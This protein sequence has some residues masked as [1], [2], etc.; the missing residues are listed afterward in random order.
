[1]LDDLTVSVLNRFKYYLKAERGLAENSIKC[2]TEDL[3]QFLHW[4][5]KRFDTVESTELIQYFSLLFEL[6]LASSSVSRKRSS[7]K[8]FYDHLS[9]NEV[10]HLVDFDKILSI[11]SEKY[12]P[13][14]LSVDEMLIILN[15]IER[16][17]A[18]GKRNK[19]ILELMYA[20]GIRI[21]EMLNLCLHD[22]L[23]KDELIRVKGKGNKQRFVPI[24][25]IAIETVNEYLNESRPVL[26]QQNITDVV[27]LNYTGD[28]MSRMGFWKILRQIVIKAGIYKE[29]SPHTIRHSFAT[30]LLEAGANLRVVQELL[31]H[32]SIKTTQI[33]THI[34]LTFLKEEHSQ[35]HPRNKKKL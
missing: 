17:D 9:E 22:L 23:F 5:D 20:S 13:D 19:A 21:S 34:D 15:S 32:S 16:N 1:M 31:G 12:L 2:Y 27:F 14:V 30:Q 29:I 18:I 3:I 8:S 26:K 11:K 7:I 28:K 25:E 6:G 4:T 35:Y 10:D 24:N 33:Y